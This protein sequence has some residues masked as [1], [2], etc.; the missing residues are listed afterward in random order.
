MILNIE[1]CNGS[2]VTGLALLFGSGIP[3]K[4]KGLISLTLSPVQVFTS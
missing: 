2:L 3:W 4:C 1:L